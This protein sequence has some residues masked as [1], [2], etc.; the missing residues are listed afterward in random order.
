MPW[1][2]PEW[3]KQANSQREEKSSAEAL[4]PLNGGTILS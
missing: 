3:L 4:L 1:G 2:A